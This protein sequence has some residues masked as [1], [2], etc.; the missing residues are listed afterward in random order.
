M[1]RRWQSLWLSLPAFSLSHA[2]GGHYLTQSPEGYGSWNP[3]P[4]VRS[5]AKGTDEPRTRGPSHPWS[6]ETRRDVSPN[7]DILRIKGSE[8]WLGSQRGRRNPAPRLL[9]PG[10]PDASLAQTKKVRSWGGR[11]RSPGRA[12]GE[13]DSLYPGQGEREEGV[14]CEDAGG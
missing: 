5:K 12:P 6:V 4:L 9:G 11:Q 14:S 1:D 7:G 2:G 13:C 10:M 3:S 8:G